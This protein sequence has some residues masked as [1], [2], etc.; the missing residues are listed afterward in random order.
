[1]SPKDIRVPLQVFD[2][3]TEKFFLPQGVPIKDAIG[4]LV[5]VTLVSDR[6]HASAAN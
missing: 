2:N 4:R 1:M 3:G 6:C 5:G